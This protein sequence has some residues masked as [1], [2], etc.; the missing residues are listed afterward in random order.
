M[1]VDTWFEKNKFKCDS[2]R[3]IKNLVKLK[4]EQKKTI[5]VV[6]PTLNEEKSVAKV[7]SKVKILQ[8]KKL[9]DEII[10]MDSGSTDRTK[11]IVKAAGAD[12]Y[13]SK[14]ILKR[15]KDIKGKG[16][17]LWKSLYVANGDIICWIDADIKNIHSRFVYGLVGPLLTKKKLKFTKA[18]Y[19]RPLKVGEKF[20]PLG[21]GRVTELTIRPLFNMYFPLLSGFIQPLSGEYAGKRDLLERIPFFTGY[22][23]ETAM[24]ID[25]QKKFGLEVCAQVDL[26]KK[27]HR[28]QSLINLSRMSFGILGV[29]AKRANALGKLILMGKTRKRYRL[30]EFEDGQY[31]L[32]QFNINDKQRPPMITINEY[33]KKFKKD[34]KWLYS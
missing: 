32:K 4:K 24:L 10:I 9:V 17:N 5:S 31:K 27:I 7:I 13:Y 34:P 19:K 1:N 29:F 23:V 21:G 25:I 14:D 12:F 30:I 8:K 33:R 3:D 11:E 28:N 2:F 26:K 22:G 6:I 18:F 15:H 20:A 16:E